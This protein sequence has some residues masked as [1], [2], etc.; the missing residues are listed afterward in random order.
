MR[1]RHSAKIGTFAMP[2][3]IPQRPEINTGGMQRPPEPESISAE[4]D[5]AIGVIYF[6][7]ST[8]IEKMAKD[9]LV[10]LAFVLL[11]S[12]CALLAAPGV[13]EAGSLAGV[14]VPGASGVLGTE[15]TVAVNHSWIRANNVQAN[16][17]EAEL[18][19]LQKAQRNAERSRAATVGMLESLAK[20]DDDPEIAD[21]VIWV[22]QGGDPQY[23]LG[24]AL[25]RD[26]TDAS[27]AAAVRILENI[28]QRRDDPEIYELAQWVREGG[29]EQ[30]ALNYALTHEPRQ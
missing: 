13:E 19:N 28:S 12:G 11:F 22:K 2:R 26:K 20:S 29:N 5:F 4:A 30:F 21:L 27:R 6:R 18:I 10:S 1:H 3:A 23:A 8:R 7:I 14:A 17:S 15:S 25:A 16:Y 9:F 24:T